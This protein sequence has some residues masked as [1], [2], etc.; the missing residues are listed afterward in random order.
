MEEKIVE[1]T[2]NDRLNDFIGMFICHDHITNIYNNLDELRKRRNRV[3]DPSEIRHAF[4]MGDSGVGKTTLVRTYVENNPRSKG[5]EKDHIP[6][7]KAEVPKPL[8]I[9]SFYD[10]ILSS[11][12][13][14]E[15]RRETVD[16]KKRRVVHHLKGLGTEMLILDEFQHIAKTARMSE[17]MM[18]VVKHLAN[19]SNVVVVCVGHTIINTLRLSSTQYK[20]RFIPIKLQSFAECDLNFTNLLWNIEGRLDLK[21]KSHLWDTDTG[22]PQWLHEVSGGVIG[23]L[24][25]Y[26]EDAY[27]LAIT[28]DK[29][30]YC[31]ERIDKEI[32]KELIDNT[33]DE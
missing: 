30:G 3:K 26:I 14:L 29:K 16:E 19:I 1:K 9:G 33:P 21:N 4:I 27:K 10:S 12:G 5:I 31:K 28:P 25:S 17:E 2:K 22:M 15:V 11:M 20:R 8:S 32:L 24:M 18:D 6:V 7:V 13:A 23:L